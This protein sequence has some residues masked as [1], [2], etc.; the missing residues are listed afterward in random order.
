MKIEKEQ[1]LV[2]M[3]RF[4]GIKA[5]NLDDHCGKVILEGDELKYDKHG[6]RRYY[7]HI[8]FAIKAAMRELGDDVDSIR[9]ALKVKCSTFK[10]ALME[11]SK[12]G[13]EPVKAWPYLSDIKDSGIEVVGGK[14]FNPNKPYGMPF[15][16][17]G[18]DALVVC[19]TI[20]QLRKFLNYANNHLRYINGSSYI[21]NDEKV[22]RMLELFKKYDLF[23]PYDSFSEFY[24]GCSIV[25]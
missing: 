2:Y 4:L 23:K 8:S 19:G 13:I 12:N 22:E 21:Y 18:G 14:H 11:K 3:M 25:D 7:T 24:H 17:K 20:D 16:D 15:V 6:S 10:V 5:I 9:E 1:E